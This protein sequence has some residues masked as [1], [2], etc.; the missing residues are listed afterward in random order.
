[1]LLLKIII[2]MN[3]PSHHQHPF[4][5]A[6]D[7]D[8]DVDLLVVYFSPEM[9]QR[10]AEG[11]EPQNAIGK[12]E[13]YYQGFSK[14]NEI[15]PDWTNRTHL[16][17]GSLRSATLLNVITQ[18]IRCRTKWYAWAEAPHQAINWRRKLKNLVGHP[19]KVC[20]KVV[21]NAYARGLFVISDN[22]REYYQ[23]LGVRP[24]KMYLLPYSVGLATDNENVPDG[25]ITNFR[26]SRGV[27]FG[28]VGSLM[29]LKGVDTILHAFAHHS[30]LFP[31][32]QLALVG[33]D[34]SEGGYLS[35]TTELGI[36]DR[37][38]FRG[39]VPSGEV[40]NVMSAIDVFVLFSRYDGW[41][42]VLS[43]AA[44]AGKPLIS[45]KVCGAGIHLI[46]DCENGRLYDKPTRENLI[47]AFG[48]YARRPEII[49]VH[50]KRSGIQAL[51]FTGP[52]NASRLKKAM[53]ENGLA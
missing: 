51:E 1:V 40:V 2:W 23:Q 50:G 52:A 27:L 44:M 53:L 36:R 37:V 28:Y 16:L 9:A 4:F 19:A 38:L 3:I 6:L 32:D 8:E 18:L 17:G 14:F 26:S 41:G 47:D 43:E 20:F 49:S 46:E 30:E 48:Y 15:C 45:S 10:V 5:K 21:I 7:D 25:I 42:M 35:M 33:I 22:A 12:T 39:R 24:D 29:A 13:Y 31:D 34:K 11:W